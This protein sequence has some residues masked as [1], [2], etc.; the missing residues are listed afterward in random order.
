MVGA[1]NYQ[2]EGKKSIGDGGKYGRVWTGMSEG[3]CYVI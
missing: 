3:F 2:A 1:I